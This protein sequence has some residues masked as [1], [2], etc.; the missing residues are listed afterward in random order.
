MRK[1]ICILAALTALSAGPAALADNAAVYT[2]E[3]NSVNVGD[4]INSYKTVLIAPSS[5]FSNGAFTGT[6]SDIVY[7]DQSANTF[8]ASMNFMLLA[9]AADGDYTVVLGNSGETP[10]TLSF[11]IGGSVTAQDEK[12]F[13]LD[14]E[15]GTKQGITNMAFTVED[16]D[17]SKYNA[18]KVVID[19]GTANE[20]VGG[21]VLSDIFDTTISGSVNLGLQINDVPNEYVNRLSIYLSNGTSQNEKQTWTTE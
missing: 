5:S 2:S 18:I 12:M 9:G 13:L 1:F 6:T 10:E 19:E 4:S 14:T 21:Y 7:I 8:S 11:T 16:V 20:Q 17:L 15:E 3:G